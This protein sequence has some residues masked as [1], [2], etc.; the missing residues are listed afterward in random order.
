[1]SVARRGPAGQDR[2]LVGSSTQEQA[3]GIL[4]IGSVVAGRYR[5]TGRLGRGGAGSVWEAIQD[6]LDRAVA[7]KVVRPDLDARVLDEFK[8]RFLREA[9]LAG[10]LS[11]P[12]VVRIFDFGTTDDGLQYVVMERL[13]G[14]TLK[15]RVRLTGPI[16]ALEAASLAANVSR[17]LHHAHT[18]GI[19][20]RDVKPSNVMLVP[21]DEGGER[22]VLLDF[23]LVKDV[24]ADTSTTR[25]GTYLG[26]PD[27]MAPEQARGNMDVGP[28]A[29]LYSLGCV[30][31]YM[32]TGTV[33]F[34]SD[35]IV[36]LA[37]QHL[38]EPVP[39]MAE[40]APAGVRVPEGLEAIVRRCLEKQ[41][42]NRYPDLASLASELDAWIRAETAGPETVDLDEPPLPPRSRGLGIGMMVLGAGLMVIAGTAAIGGGA[43]FALGVFDREE[44]PEVVSQGIDV[45][46][47]P[48]P[49]DPAP[50]EPEEPSDAET[51]PVEEVELAEEAEEPDPE[52]IVAAPAPDPEPK[53]VAKP[54]PPEPKPV[55]KAP[56]REPKTA[57]P[58][59]AT[60]TSAV[61]VDG[62]RFEPEHAVRAL[63]WV[64]TA[65]EYDVRRAGISG[66]Q[67]NT[68]M[69][70]RPY[71]SLQD[72]GS[73]YGIGQKTVQR[74]FDATKE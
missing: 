15:Q 2:A 34:R 11:H 47:P 4:D 64:N 28:A 26:T 73:T 50:V 17:G 39:P 20:H 72:F 12:N 52:P 18:R 67:V 43:L 61:L 55:A 63:T 25:T 14:R 71:D 6:P 36:G 51:E 62:V 30:M 23:G 1:M 59:P 37:V 13:E 58:V 66:A 16:A 54:P 48:E 35:N 60:P 53:P 44:V 19:V 21:T 56:A 49:L 74:A 40:K 42:E 32:L 27:Y 69:K 24:H 41:P 3:G 7:L 57:A 46:A 29:D 22:P 5:I 31:F 10:K 45:P 70:N 65:E 38:Q 33:P 8:E 9:A 68:L